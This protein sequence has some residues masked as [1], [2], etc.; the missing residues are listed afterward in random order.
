MKTRPSSFLFLIFSASFATAAPVINH[1]DP[2]RYRKGTS[3]P[4]ADWQT[5]ADGALDASWL[6]GPGGFGYGDG[7]DATILDDM[8]DSYRT[9]YIRRAFTVGAGDLASTDKVLL[10]VDYD[11]GFV[12]YLDGIEVARA[13]APGSVGTEPAFDAGPSVTREAG[14][15]QVF[16]LG[17]VAAM[18][19]D[20][21]HILAVLGM[22]ESLGSSDLSLIVDL[23]T[24][25]PPPPIHWTLAE[26]PITLASTFNVA[27]GQTLT[28]DAGVEVR[29][30]SGTDAIA[31]SGVIE[32]NGTAA[33]RIR[34]VPATQ[35]GT[36]GR[37]L[38]QGPL[39]S[40]MDYCDFERGNSTGIVRGRN[41]DV[42]L[43]HCRFL[44][45]NVQ[46]VDFINT[47]CVI[48]YCEFDSINGAELLH[49]TT[50]PANGHALI[51]YNRFG[52]PG[53]SA[54][55]GYNDIID[56]TGG[57]RPGPIPRFIGNVFV[58][59]GD[60]VLDMD[61]TDAHI[62]GNIFMNIRKEAARSSSSNPITTGAE[63]SNRS[64]L[65]I[66]RNLFFNNEH[67]VMIKDNGTITMQ[68]NTTLTLTDNPLSN[69]TDPDGNEAPGIV[70]FGEPWRGF[71]FG[72]GVFY[73][74]N[75]AADLQ[76]TDPWP[77][78]PNALTSTGCFLVR[79]YNCVEG[80]PQPG[81]ANIS[82]DPLF[83]DRTGI[84]ETNIFQKLA[85]QPGSPC[86][87]T[88]PN[89]IN[90]GAL[91]PSGA[92]V[93]GEPIGTTSATGATLVVGG[94][95][96]WAYRWRV[97]GGAWSSEVSLVPQAIWDGA[98][99]TA[100]MFDNA[101]PIVLSG[102]ADG[103]YTVEVQGR[104][105]AKDWQE[106]PTVSK[107]WTV[108]TGPADF[109]MD[110]MPDD[111]E[112]ANMFDPMNPA[113]ADEDADGD[114]STNVQEFVAGTLPRDAS[115]VLNLEGGTIS[116]ADVTFQFEA[117]AGKSYQVQWS[118][119]LEAASWSEVETIAPGGGGV[120]MV[121]DTGGA[122]NG[123]RFYRLVTPAP[124]P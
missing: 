86:L 47:S 12:A 51:A 106:T 84:D 9:V 79:N 28:I 46:M 27:S 74:G 53:T 63:N 2:W 69:N 14:S 110:G 123:R 40:R 70:L 96:I 55:G 88:G 102:L 114:G 20:G 16:D 13:N 64:E 61:S 124:V 111:W 49:F 6:T 11:D 59:G 52:I 39:P 31:C 92:T 54:S 108:Q 72:N 109:D 7:D 45:V 15:A 81:T 107:T 87:G 73:E 43:D 26:S 85:L 19:P 122:G 34:F 103:T 50:M 94:P 90:M 1:G 95:G 62:E 38:L 5:I 98:P 91:V 100:T 83:V 3:A 101:P 71:P 57:N 22:N 25:A 75:I 93:S 80:F 82:V 76:L 115:S 30:P 4:Q 67:N 44:D 24:Q 121:T 29:C 23:A 120:Q 33:Q 21:D 10:T 105:S 18:L 41:S 78:Y 32:A 118:E 17:T 35:G 36:W 58:S 8:E 66:A 48:Q 117:V 104:N 42:T 60:D 116:G 119:N 37:V 113:D 89:G 65:V 97:N 99:F 56:F 112:T 68:N 77:I